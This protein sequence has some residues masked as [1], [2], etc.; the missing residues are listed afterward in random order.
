M[1]TTTTAAAATTTKLI[2]IRRTFQKQVLLY[3]CSKNSP[4]CPRYLGATCLH[5]MFSRP[6]SSIPGCHLSRHY[7]FKTNVL[8]PWV[9]LV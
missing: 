9:P 5:I 8:D 7:V 6:M 2:E 3:T 1:L 4:K